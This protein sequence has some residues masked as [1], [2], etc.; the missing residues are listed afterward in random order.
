MFF[1]IFQRDIVMASKKTTCAARIAASGKMPGL[2]R[3]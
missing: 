3:T 1:G 2:D